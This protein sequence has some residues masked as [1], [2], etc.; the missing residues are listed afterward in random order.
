MGYTLNLD[1]P[2]QKTTAFFFIGTILFL[3]SSYL[4]F[5][6]EPYALIGIVLSALIIIISLFA[7][8]INWFYYWNE[9]D[10]KADSFDLS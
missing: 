1:L 4:D 8:I 6:K 3:G 2:K 9:K 10:K 5:L 7:Q